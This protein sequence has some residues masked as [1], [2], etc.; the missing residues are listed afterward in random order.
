MFQSTRPTSRSTLAAAIAAVPI[1]PIAPEELVTNAELRTLAAGD[2]DRAL[3]EISINDQALLALALPHICGE[4]I[5]RRGAMAGEPFQWD[6]AA[7][8][9]IKTLRSLAQDDEHRRVG[10]LSEAD[11]LTLAMLLTDICNELRARRLVM[12]GGLA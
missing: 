10:S 1:R 3:G 8:T 6:T 5:A 2:P 12:A 4:L 11:Q 9:S 7:L